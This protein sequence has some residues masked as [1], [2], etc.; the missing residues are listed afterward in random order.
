MSFKAPSIKQQFD[1]RNQSNKSYDENYNPTERERFRK[2]AEEFVKEVNV[3]EE[4]QFLIFDSCPLDFIGKNLSIWFEKFPN[5]KQLEFFYCDLNT[6][7][8]VGMEKIKQKL[9][10][11]SLILT[12][13][14]IPKDNSLSQFLKG[15]NIKAIK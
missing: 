15:Q 6:L 4:I 14:N 3:H 13:C 2:E 9:N 8:F 5:V 12:K 10:I 7:N 11:G 1:N